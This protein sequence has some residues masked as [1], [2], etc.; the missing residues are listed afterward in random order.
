MDLSRNTNKKIRTDDNF[1]QAGIKA[2]NRRSRKFE[3]VV[4][5]DHID[6]LVVSK[7]EHAHIT[8]EIKKDNLDDAA[9]AVEE[10]MNDTVISI[11]GTN[12][13][14]VRKWFG[15]ERFRVCGKKHKSPARSETVTQRRGSAKISNGAWRIQS[16]AVGKETRLPCS[17]RKKQL[18]E[19]AEP[20]VFEH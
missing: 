11:P 1:V 10:L 4:T 8:Q 5:E 14:T 18:I 17:S 15:R 3:Q 13:E 20:H 9:I 7:W 16:T 2:H 6:E 19:E 12:Q